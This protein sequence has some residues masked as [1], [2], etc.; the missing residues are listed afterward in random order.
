MASLISQAAVAQAAEHLTRNEVAGGSNPSRRAKCE[1]CG[2]RALHMFG[3]TND[4]RCRYVDGE[5][6]NTIRARGT[7]AGGRRVRS[8][9]ARRPRDRR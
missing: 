9:A 5:I 7:V 8:Q 3:D 2:K 6:N 4:P 1:K